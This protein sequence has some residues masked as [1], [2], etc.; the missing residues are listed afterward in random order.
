MS[1][2]WLSVLVCIVAWGSGCT[3][4]P[5]GG[6]PGGSD[7]DTCET[8]PDSF[9]DELE[10]VVYEE[11]GLIDPD[12][13][14]CVYNEA[15][16]TSCDQPGLTC[17]DGECV[18]SRSDPQPCSTLLSDPRWYEATCSG[19]NQ[20]T[21]VQAA[22]SDCHVWC[23]CADPFKICRDAVL[24][25]SEGGG[26][27]PVDRVCEPALDNQ[28]SCADCTLSLHVVSVER[29]EVIASDDSRAQGPSRVTL[30]VRYTPIARVSSLAE[31]AEA[32]PKARMADIRIQANREVTLRNTDLA[33]GDL[34]VDVEIGESTVAAGKRLYLDPKTGE[35]WRRLDH[36]D[37]VAEQRPEF[38]FLVFADDNTTR[39]EAGVIMRVTFTVR[40]P[41][42]VSFWLTKR[43]QILAPESSD[44]ALQS[45]GAP[46]L[47]Y[48]RAVIINSTGG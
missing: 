4:T 37:Y 12:T 8:P 20:C 7:P 33:R 13:D 29:T 26:E 19:E 11:T 36:G 15:S 38:R 16:R 9:C 23:G 27:V 45:D 10:A 3:S 44:Q 34:N 17:R 25:E 42:A 46:G 39:L 31:E 24:P 21:R 22:E 1:I 2:R 40:E 5:G 28:I 32:E 6:T 35:H 47:E 18:W 43:L 30:E 41:K 14:A 48:S